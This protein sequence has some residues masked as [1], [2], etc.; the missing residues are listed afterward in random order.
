MQRIAIV[1]SGIAGLS[2]ARLLSRPTPGAPLGHAVTLF[3]AGS[4]FGGHAHTV[5]VTLNAVSHGVDTG[6][7]VFNHRTYPGLTRLFDEL[8]VQTAPAEMSFSV[9]A[10]E[11]AMSPALEWSGTDLNGVFAQRRNMLRPDFLRMLADILRFNRLT[12]ALALAADQGNETSAAS[13]ASSASGASGASGMAL[14]QTVGEFLDQHRFSDVFRRWY[15]LP[16]IACIWSCPA[17]QML[18]FPMLTLVRFCHNHGLL[19]VSNRP[20]WRTVRGGSRQYVRRIVQG[21]ADARLNTPVLAVHRD[22]SGVR[23]NTAHGSEHF[24]ELVLACHS[25]QALRLLGAGA[26][27]DERRVLGAIRYQPN[28]AVLHTD[29]ALLPQQP[30]AWAA[31]NYETQAGVGAQSTAEAGGNVQT[32]ARAGVCLHYLINRLQ[33]LPWQQPVLVSL[34]PLR[35]PRV[36]QVIAEFSVDHPVFDQGALAAQRELPGLQGQ[37]N[38]WFCGAWTGYGF[39]EDGLVSG[40]RVADALLAAPPM[41]QARVA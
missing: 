20:Q 21:L 10:R 5:D 38:T 33:P 11:A 3:E 9:Q 28:R 8:G 23:V 30:R 4:H 15:L 25:D 40:Q 29:T 34:N 32:P 2:A 7:L 31:W 41:L 19:Q 6:F 1:G 17:R 16:M 24:D 18:A 37:H 39:H 36:D 12:T 13:G 35:A 27:A 22:A 14:Q 26:T